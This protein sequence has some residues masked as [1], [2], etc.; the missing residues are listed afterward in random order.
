VKQ[1]FV[2]LWEL[3]TFTHFDRRLS[4]MRLYMQFVDGAMIAR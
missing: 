2:Q 4:H 1:H 3:H